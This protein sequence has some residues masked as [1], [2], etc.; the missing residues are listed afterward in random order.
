MSSFLKRAATNNAPKVVGTK[1]S[2]NTKYLLHFSGFLL[3]CM[4]CLIVLREKAFSEELNRKR[5]G[6][7]SDEAHEQSIQELQEALQRQKAAREQVGFTTIA[8]TDYKMVPVPK[9]EIP[10]DLSQWEAQ[11]P[12]RRS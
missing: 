8:K 5:P 3:T 7:F 12:S 11:L 2:G 10:Q 9:K 1:S 6:T 4:G